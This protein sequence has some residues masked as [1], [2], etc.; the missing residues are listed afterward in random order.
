MRSEV[1]EKNT[2][3]ENSRRINNQSHQ[4]FFILLMFNPYWKTGLPGHTWTEI[5]LPQRAGTNLPDM[6]PKRYC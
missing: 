1:N 5:P 4:N 3:K 2:V 6:H